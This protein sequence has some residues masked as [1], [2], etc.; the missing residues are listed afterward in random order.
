MSYDSFLYVYSNPINST[1]PTGYQPGF[2]GPAAFATCFGIHSGSQSET[3][4]RF[5]GV[6]SQF[7][8]D[9][10][11]ADDAVAI[12]QAAYS[13]AAWSAFTGTFGFDKKLPQSAHELMGWF[14]Y[15]HG[16]TEL[17]FNGEEQLT[18]ELSVSTQVQ[19]I[20]D[21]YYQQGDTAKPEYNPFGER[22][23]LETVEG[24]SRNSAVRGSLP[25]SLFI[26]S[27]WYQIKT[28]RGQDGRIRVGFRIDNDTTLESG[29]HIA[30]RFEPEFAGSVEDYLSTHRDQG[31]RPIQAIMNEHKFI[32]ILSSYARGTNP[33]GGGNQYQTYVW[34]ERRDPCEESK[35]YEK[36]DVKL[37]GVGVWLGYD[38]F[39]EDPL[40]D[41]KNRFH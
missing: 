30:N 25:I 20:R 29:S 39:T 27:F 22:E 4:R 33:R 1:D 2:A 40:R 34:S 9:R 5:I 18:R 11:T 3:V 32:S 16:D 31:S 37:L 36:N 23:T 10:I 24:D 8:M 28:I 15:E 14:V 26:G 7:I 6:P 38:V 21:Q 13:Q 19:R 12:C 41:L 17:V 35:M